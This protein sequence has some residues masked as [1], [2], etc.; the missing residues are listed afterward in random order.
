MKT[1]FHIVLGSFFIFLF[2]WVLVYKSGVNPLVIQSEDSLPTMFL[3]F[4]IIKKGSLYL[5]D[6]Y[7]MLI[8][9]YP[10][11]DDK[12]YVKG[13]TPFYLKKVG[14]H[15]VSAFPIMT[16]I[17]ALPVYIIPVISGT[18][19][20]WENVTFLSKISSFLIVSLSGGFLYLLLK[21]HFVKDNKKSILL[22][23]I[24]LFASVNFAMVS[25][26][27]WQHGAVQ[28]FSILGLYFLF[29]FLDSKNHKD[30]FL[31][32][33]FFGLAI[34]SRPT[35]AL[36][37]IF[38]GLLSY[39]K[40]PDWKIYIKSSLFLVLGVLPSILFF[41]LYNQIFYEG[42]SNQGYAS[43]IFTSWVSPFPISFLGVWLSP[44]KGIL[45]YSPIFIACFVGL[46]LAMK[47][48]VI[49]NIDY[50]IFGI[51]VL[52]HTLII[53]FW[54]HWYGGYS[55]GYRMSSDIIPYLILLMVPFVNSV[56]FDKY[57][58]LFMGLFIFS[59]LVE[60]FGMVF[61]DG[62]WHAAYDLGYENTLWLWSVKNSELLFNIRRVLVKFGVLERA[63]PQCL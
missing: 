35:A 57:K 50:L 62:I 37:L 39:F 17:V 55:F 10:H 56:F 4:S 27:M 7:D 26:A 21:K 23:L 14:N 32:G 54:K 60:V 48:G 31:T 41:F 16:A 58:K 52:L 33:L 5:D 6:F 12:S 38:I 34:I 20:T 9:K 8:E 59:I 25:Q 42:L 11:P 3:P 43:Q 22:T 15:Y 45:I 36:A 2:S 53:S 28:L 18:L 47:K 13:L 61:F 24:Y 29:N 46:Y 19:P 40:I 51:I 63:C 1:F 30:M 44:S 49:K